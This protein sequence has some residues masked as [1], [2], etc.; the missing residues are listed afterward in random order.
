MAGETS[1][2]IR[3]TASGAG[4]SITGADEIV[5]FNS[6]GP[7][8]QEVVSG[9][10]TG[11]GFRFN[12]MLVQTQL[13][14]VAMKASVDCII[15]TNDPDDEDADDHI[16]L[17]AGVLVV[18]TPKRPALHNPFQ[19]NCSSCYLKFAATSCLLQIATGSDIVPA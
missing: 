9:P 2:I 17:S 10:Q 5:T 11:D 7:G 4:E 12:L 18:W 6:P 8:F 3:V 15:N 16:V 19:H 14:Y 13:K 1:A